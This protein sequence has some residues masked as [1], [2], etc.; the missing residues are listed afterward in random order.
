MPRR[1]SSL[2]GPDIDYCAFVSYSHENR[3]VAVAVT[4]ALKRIAVYYSCCFPVC[5]RA[6]A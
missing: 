4:R 1:G 3:P 6:A 2:G 5:D